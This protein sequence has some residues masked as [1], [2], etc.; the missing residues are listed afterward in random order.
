MNNTTVGVRPMSQVK[1]L[2]KTYLKKLKTR[3]VLARS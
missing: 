3:E 1:K 2:K